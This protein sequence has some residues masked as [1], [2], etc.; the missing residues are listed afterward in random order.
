MQNIPPELRIAVTD[1]D[2]DALIELYEFDLTPIGGSRYRF[3]DGVNQHHQSLIWQ[4]NTYEPY[5]IKGEGFMFNG[6]GPSGRP[7]VTLSNLFGLV[8]G[9]ASRLDSAVG[10]WVI[11]RVISTRFLDAENFPNGN[12]DADPTQ[13]MVSRWVIEQMTSLN[14]E[15]ATFELAA[16]SETEGLMLPARVILSDICAW[17]YRSIECGYTGSPVADELGNPT[18]NPAADKCGKRPSDCKLRN[19]TARIGCFLSTSRL[20]Q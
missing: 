16:P 13:E 4:K 12:L 20:G 2:G 6:K 15:T 3:Y 18:A 11:R 1:L 8:T 10:G 5:P 19:N 9:I 17:E 7:T 14:A